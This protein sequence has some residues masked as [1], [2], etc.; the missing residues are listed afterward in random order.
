[1][2][3]ILQEPLLAVTVTTTK[4]DNSQL[5]N[6]E[7]TQN[8]KSLHQHH[9]T[10]RGDVLQALALHA[11]GCFDVLAI[12]EGCSGGMRQQVSFGKYTHLQ[13]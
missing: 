10:P 13:L 11:P 6:Q 7:V 8:C 5:D 9:R 4:K 3:F 1:M 2:A 12:S